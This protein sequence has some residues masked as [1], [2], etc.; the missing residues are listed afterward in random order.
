MRSCAVLIVAVLG[1]D[2][3]P[4][5]ATIIAAPARSVATPRDVSTSLAPLRLALA[6]ACAA[7]APAARAG[8][9]Y[10]P[11]HAQFGVYKLDINQ[12]NYI[13]QDMVDKLKVGQTSSRS[14]STSARRWSTSAFRDNRWDYIYEYTRQGRTVEH[15][16]FTSYFNDDKL[17]RW[18]GDEM[19]VSARAAQPHRRRPRARARTRGSGRRRQSPGN[20]SSTCFEAA[21]GERARR[22]SPAPAAAWARRWSKRSLARPRPDARGRARRGRRRRAS[23]ATPASGSGVRTAR[24]RPTSRVRTRA[25]DVLID[26]TRP[27]GTLA[28]RAAC[29]RHRV[30]LVV[31]HDRADR[32]R[33]RRSSPRM[34]APIPIVFAPNMSVGVN[35]LATLVEIAASRAGS[36]VRHRDRRDASPAQGRCAVGNRAAAG[37]G[38]RDGDVGRRSSAPASSPATASPAR[39]RAGAIG[40]AALRGGDVVGEHTVIFADRRRAHRAHAPRHVAADVRG[41]R[42][43]R[44]AVRGSAAC[45]AARPVCSTCPTC[46]TCD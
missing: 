27:E 30:A 35:V 5:A 46:W 13:T 45:G 34:R 31:G 44:R 38:G 39:A 32:R 2:S 23:A 18:E 8:R 7:L 21:T 24:R 22:R 43:A 20:A 17:A 11:D 37:R 29:A 33:R 12:G 6:A 4:G 42:A 16:Q 14:G 19:P 26:F 25:C 28:H 40:F 10:M 9:D 41:R 15:R 1:R 3:V 36:R